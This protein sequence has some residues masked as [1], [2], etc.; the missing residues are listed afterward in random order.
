MA[1][2]REVK[3]TGLYKGYWR[4]GGWIKGHTEVWVGIMR[5]TRKEIYGTEI[6]EVARDQREE[7]R[8]W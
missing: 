7:I 8:N 6:K 5:R 3:G 4:C 1:R 2:E